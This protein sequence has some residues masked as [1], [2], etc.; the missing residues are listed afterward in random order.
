MMSGVTYILIT[1]KT[2]HY[3]RE[4]TLWVSKRHQYSTRNHLWKLLWH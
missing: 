4:R 2:G 3:V 1:T